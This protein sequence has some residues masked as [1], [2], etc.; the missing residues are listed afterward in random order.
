MAHQRY[1]IKKAHMAAKATGA[2]QRGHKR[3]G[4]QRTVKKAPPP[5]RA[6]FAAPAPVQYPRVSGWSPACVAALQV[7]VS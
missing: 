4:H 1:T 5:Q 6:T 3:V 7:S 2:D